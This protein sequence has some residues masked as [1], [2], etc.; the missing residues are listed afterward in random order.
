MS[1]APEIGSIGANEHGVRL[2]GR[3][4]DH[5]EVRVESVDQEDVGVTGGP[6]HDLGSRGATP[7]DAVRRDVFGPSVRFGFDDS[8]RD[9]S[10]GRA[11]HEHLA[12][13]VVRHGQ[14]GPGVKR[15]WQRP[16]PSP[17]GERWRQCGRSCAEG[18]SGYHVP[19]I[20]DAPSIW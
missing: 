1:G 5:V 14:D 19:S 3:P 13:A 16:S 4:G 6:E 12:D 18:S 9:A 2:S 11:A 10:R 7:A 15:A 8:P 17:S 20:P